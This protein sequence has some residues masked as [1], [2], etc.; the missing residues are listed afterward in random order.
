MPYHHYCG[1]RTGEENGARQLPPHPRTHTH[2]STPATHH[3]GGHEHEKLHTRTDEHRQR[4]GAER[5]TGRTEHVA[6]HQLPATVFHRLFQR[7]VV[8]PCDVLAHHAHHDHGHHACEQHHHQHRV[9][10]GEPVYAIV[11]GVGQVAGGGGTAGSTRHTGGHEPCKH[12]SATFISSR[13]NSFRAA[14]GGETTYMFQ[15]SVHLT[16]LGSHLT[17]YVNTTSPPR[18]MR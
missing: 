7:R 18:S 9:G 14:A 11:R 3:D 4:N 17:S 5:S 12:A 1:E 6:M 16:S 15:R 13:T 8:V 10:D 2:S